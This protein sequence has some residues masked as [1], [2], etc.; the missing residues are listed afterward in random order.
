MGPW[1]AEHPSAG[2]IVLLAI[3]IAAG[4]ALGH[5]R[6]R[7]VGLGVAGVLLV[8]LGLSAS[9][10]IVD[11]NVLKFARDLGLVLFVFCV[12]LQI[13]PGFFVSLKRA[14]LGLNIIAAGIVLLGAGIMLAIIKLGL[15]NLQDGLGVL[16]GATTNTPSLAAGQAAMSERGLDPG[17]STAGY[18]FAY[19][20]GV[21]G[22]IGVMIGSARLARVLPS[23]Q[24]PTQSAPAPAESVGHATI[25]VSN[26]SVAG[27]ELRR[28]GI[29]HSL[30]VVLTRHL[31]GQHVS[32]PTGETRL[33]LG[34]LVLAVGGRAEIDQLIILLGRASETDLRMH[35]GQVAAQKLVVTRI[36]VVG[37]SMLELDLVR[38]FGVQISRV[39]R[40][41]VEMA[42]RGELVVQ[43][44]D[45]LTAVGPEDAL[46][47]VRALVGNSQR[48]LNQ[49]HLIPMFLGIC[50]GVLIGSIPIPLP[51]LSTP[52]KLGLAAGPMLV[53]LLFARLG[54][55]GPMICS[56][57]AP[58]N[59]AIRE[60]GIALFMASVGLLS[61]G[62]ML[63]AIHGTAVLTWLACAL[64]VVLLP[65]LVGAVV[66]RVWLNLDGPSTMGLLAGSM[67]DPPALSLAGELSRND[68]PA[69]TYTAVYP[70]AMVL[71]IAAMQVIVTI[72][73]G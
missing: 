33:Q 61:G 26:P 18:A 25:E 44:G 31:S 14:G 72:V 23:L 10:V 3:C 9:G 35:S 32:V 54:R 36:E 68:A 58:A 38:R 60:T 28:L 39:E 71:R 21:L 69:L 6:V 8:G 65:L 62:A 15:L 46:P 45:V 42:A 57:P 12:G 5:V 7:G 73:L 51:G 70:L 40:A 48:A 19:P 29:I 41:G 27:I 37:Q 30:G 53:A 67:T 20:L 50:C 64:A 56:M 13:G 47:R 55:L 34:D 66:A 63:E 11:A 22:T 49:P 17:A 43:F 52:I 1:L 2:A 4:L 24:P 16:A 59:A